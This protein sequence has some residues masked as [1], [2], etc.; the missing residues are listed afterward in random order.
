MPKLNR[1]DFLKVSAAGTATVILAGCQSA[2]R[3]EVLEPYV[4]SPE[5]Q[6]AGVPSFYATTCRQC[7][8]GCG[9]VARIMNGRAIKLE[10]NPDHPVN[11]GK[12][13]ARGQAGLQLLYN[14]D[15]LPTPVQ[16]AE[17][18]SRDFEPLATNEALNLLLEKVQAADGQ[19]AVWLGSSTSSHLHDLFRRFTRALGAPEPVRFDLYGSFN[20]YDVL[21][22][23]SAQVFDRAAL[24]TY[25][26][27]HADVIF[28]FGADM[29]GTWLSATGYGVEYGHFRSQD[30]GKRGYM[31]QFEPRLSAT[32][33]AA[34]RWVPITPGTEAVL[35]QAFARIIAADESFGPDE[36]AQV[37]DTCG[38][39]LEEMEK[40][41]ALFAEAETPLAIPGSTVTGR[42]NAVDATA[43]VQALNLIAGTVGQPGGMS[44]TPALADTNL[45]RPAASSLAD[46]TALIEQMN[47][48]EVKLLLVHGA[49]PA[50]DLPPDSGFAE[51]LENVDTVVSFN[52]LVD[53]TG[54]LADL[55]MPDRTY[56]ESWGYEVVTPG[57]GGVPVV[58]SQ[59]PVVPQ[60]YELPS[61]GDVLLTL[62]K[63]LPET[64]G[65]LAWET[66]VD[67]IREM[68]VG[69]GSGTEKEAQWKGFLQRGGWWPETPP[70]DAAPEAP[71][72]QPVEIAAATF[73]G[74]ADE[75]PYHLHLYLSTLLGDGSGASQPWLQGT[76]DPMTTVSWQSWVELNPTVADEL[77]VKSGDI[78]RVTSVHG[79]IEAPAYVY[80]GI[81]PDTV[82]IPLGQG[83]TDLGRY[84]RER[85]SNPVRLAG[86]QGDRMAWANLR[87]KIERTGE[88][89]PSAVFE[90]TIEPEEFVHAPV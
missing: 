28:S 81:R 29:L 16:Q 40:L 15:R 55:I 47:A 58:S 38:V 88:H 70:A 51:A 74:N 20:G 45:V 33:T 64:S 61:T 36:R 57:F 25:D 18:G 14:P 50:Y 8:A 49:N 56:L 44:L 34:D 21:A 76:P 4:N 59:Q 60:F 68:V 19:I 87:V 75:Y 23:A 11:R 72:P 12:L 53:E 42:D 85:G 48:G 67:F 86:T 7:P 69:T 30:F 80:P 37:A 1:R 13:C 84:A 22:D 3:W 10:G 6:L 9:V 83:H 89:Q 32:G 46:A 17:R 54:A 31:V 52:S 73:Q 78:L 65:E 41:A 66:E 62:A 90:S 43:A 27:G 24:P 79:A 35:A 5:Q 39:K 2:E 63:G 26:L 71:E 77:G 82:A